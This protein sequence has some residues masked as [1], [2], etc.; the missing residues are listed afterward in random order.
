LLGG[1]SSG[2][3]GDVVGVALPVT[4]E[5]G[6]RI[7]PHWYFGG[8]ASFAYATGTN[9]AS[10]GTDVA[11][12]YETDYRFGVDL[13]YRILPRATFQPWV[14][15]GVGWEILNEIS[16][17]EEGD[18]ESSSINGVEFTHVD[19]GLD[20]RVNDYSKIGPYFQA[21]F[22]TYD[23]GYIHEWYTVGARWRFDTNWH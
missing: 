17:D 20:Y 22:A 21:A 7:S 3:L 5:L 9:C 6:W 2:L 18:E 12:C 19:V 4:L 1:S 16:T 11:S 10:S 8:Y 23:N 13:Q 14:G 15:V